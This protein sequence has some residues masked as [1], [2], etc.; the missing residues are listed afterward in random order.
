MKGNSFSVRL[1]SDSSI[2]AYGFSIT[3][4]MP[5]SRDELCSVTL[6]TGIEGEE[7]YSTYL[8]KNSGIDLAVSLPSPAVY[9]KAFA[10]WAYEPDGDI[11]LS[12]I[13]DIKN[14]INGRESIEL[15]AKWITPYLA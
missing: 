1:V 9:G 12:D 10:G 3:Q 5:V 8:S 6:H 7:P 15:Y 4:V 14:I 2:N 13:S 11:V